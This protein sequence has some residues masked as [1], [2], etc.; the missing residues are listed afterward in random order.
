M[1]LKAED[2]KDSKEHTPQ[3]PWLNMFL[4]LPLDRSD[5]EFADWSQYPETAGLLR[6]CQSRIGG[7]GG[8][9]TEQSHHS[10]PAIL[11]ASGTIIHLQI[12]SSEAEHFNAERWHPWRQQAGRPC[13]RAR[14][15]I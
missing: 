6:D 11:A 1:H 5:L 14:L 4:R 3:A 9:K 10:L 13:T 8:W 15:C 2:E 12:P 7:Y